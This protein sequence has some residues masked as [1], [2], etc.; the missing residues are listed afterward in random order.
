MTLIDDL[1]NLKEIYN[2][3]GKI[4]DA[5]LKKYDYPDDIKELIK[6][7]FNLF[8]NFI[9]MYQDETILKIQNNNFSYHNISKIKNYEFIVD[10]LIHIHF[11]D[12]FIEESILI[13][14]DDLSESKPIDNFQ[15][16]I[17]QIE[18]FNKIENEGLVTGIHNQA[19]G[20]GK[21]IIIIKYIHH[22][23]VNIQNPKIILFTERISI[24]KDLFDF[25]KGSHNPNINKSDGGRVRLFT[26][27]S[28]A[29][30]LSSEISARLEAGSSIATD[31]ST[32]VSAEESARLSTESSIATELSSEIAALA[33]VD[34]T[35]IVL[36]G[37]TNQIELK[38][39]IAAPAS[40]IR[41]FAGEVDVETILKVGGVD[42]MAA[43]A[44]GDASL[45][46]A[47]ST[48]VSYLIANTDLGSI[49]SFAEVV[50]DLSSEVLRAESAEANL[51][52]TYYQKLTL[53][54]DVDGTNAQFSFNNLIMPDSESIYLNGLLMTVGDDYTTNGTSVTFN[55]AP[56]VGDKVKAYAVQGPSVP[57]S[58]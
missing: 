41:T 15:L 9:K 58:A 36:N 3:Y 31:L 57:M 10:W 22:A 56:Q 32:A 14:N 44:S 48:E 33:D 12:Q 40:G 6:I 11:F 23:I 7:N 49:D 26:D 21:S 25:T 35:T 2:D 37:D 20:C 4:T 28:L 30:D 47:L 39:T 24:L 34:G 18:A 8:E 50:A 54:G 55:N 42:V 43:M 52:A 19:T 53:I 46:V 51:L 45:E 38:E 13:N 29:L 5:M 27:A 1:Q 17:N 16:R